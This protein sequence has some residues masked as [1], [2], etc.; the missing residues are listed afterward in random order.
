MNRLIHLLHEPTVLFLDEPSSGLDPEAAL[1]VRQFIGELRGEGRA[2]LITTHNLDEADRLCDRIAVFKA[3][4]LALD[5]PANLRHQLYG[6]TVVFHLAQAEEK[7]ANAIAAKDYVTSAKVVDGKI[8]VTLTDPEKYNPELIRLLVEGGAEIR[9]VG[10][11]R[12]TLEDVYLHLIKNG[13]A[14]EENHG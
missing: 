7:F 6:R 14:S 8:L 9:F 10:E 12:H 5:T 13:A 3:S 1:I 4:L 11:L 2:I